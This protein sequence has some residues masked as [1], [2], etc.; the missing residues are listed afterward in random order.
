MS[1]DAYLALMCELRDQR[2]N[3]KRLSQADFIRLA[4]QAYVRLQ[5]GSRVAP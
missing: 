2:F 3:H 4:N 5:N 1:W